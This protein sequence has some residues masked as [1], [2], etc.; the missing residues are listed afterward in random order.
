MADSIGNFN[1][2]HLRVEPDMGLKP[3]VLRVVGRKVVLRCAAAAAPHVVSLLLLPLL[4]GGGW[5]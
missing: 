1:G 3:E 2:M 4:R 5:P